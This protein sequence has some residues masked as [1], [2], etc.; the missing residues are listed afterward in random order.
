MNGD[1]SYLSVASGGNPLKAAMGASI[2][3]VA[4][5]TNPRTGMPTNCLVLPEAVESGLKLEGN[6]E[7]GAL[8]TL[9]SPG[10]L[11]AS[12][13]AFDPSG[14]DTLKKNFQMKLPAERFNDRRQLLAELD[15]VKRQVD[16]SGVMDNMDRF[17]QQAFDVITRGVAEAFDLSKE[18]PKAIE[19]YDTAKLFKREDI[20]KWYDMRRALEPARQA[21]AAGPATVRSGVR[22]RDRLGLRLGHAR[23]RKQPQKHGQ[24]AADDQPGGSR[25]RRLY[26]GRPRTRPERQDP[27]RGHRRDGPHSAAQPQRRPRPLCQPDD[28]VVGRRRA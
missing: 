4:G 17:Q 20:T 8:P 27:P 25:R 19:K 15:S 10:E 22:L 16:R 14:G 3:R 7:T 12:F 5:T 11:G 18:D 1:H 13:G 9:T 2:S 23:Q 28:A 24:P 26:R 21:D 6:F